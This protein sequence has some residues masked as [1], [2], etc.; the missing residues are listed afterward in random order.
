MRKAKED[1]RYVYVAVIMIAAFMA[2]YVCRSWREGAPSVGRSPIERCGQTR[3]EPDFLGG[4]VETRPF[5]I[6]PVSSAR[7]TGEYL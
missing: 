4:A 2:G 5:I 6:L 7:K 1:L 3:F